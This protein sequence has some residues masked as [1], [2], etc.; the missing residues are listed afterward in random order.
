MAV[1][2]YIRT[3]TQ[4]LNGAVSHLQ[5]EIKELRSQLDRDVRGLQQEISNAQTQMNVLDQQAN[6]AVDNADQ[7]RIQSLIAI[8]KH[9]ISDKQKETSLLEADLNKLIQD[10]ERLTQQLL[11]ATRQVEQLS[12]SSLLR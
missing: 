5:N 6:I 11:D 2:E 4:N 7:A 8:E 10:K 9:R 3:A 1:Q 12:F